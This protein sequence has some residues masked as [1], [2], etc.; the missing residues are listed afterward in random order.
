MFGTIHFPFFHSFILASLF[1]LLYSLFF[2]FS[3]FEEER[4]EKER[5]GKEREKEKQNTGKEECFIPTMVVAAGIGLDF[6]DDEFLLS[7]PKVHL[8]SPPEVPRLQNDADEVS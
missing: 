1:C 8:P 5:K 6:G 2:F 4:K 7:I 3:L